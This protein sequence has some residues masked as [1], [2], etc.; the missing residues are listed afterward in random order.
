MNEYTYI[1]YKNDKRIGKI[2][3]G[4]RNSVPDSKE[5]EKAVK[6]CFPNGCTTELLIPVQICINQ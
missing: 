5:I 2:E 4:K 6:E 1:V 3:F